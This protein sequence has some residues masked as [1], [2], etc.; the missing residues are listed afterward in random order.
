MAITF[1]EKSELGK[2]IAIVVVLV[3]ISSG[4]GFLGWKLSQDVPVETVTTAPTIIR[5]DKTILEDARLASLEK[6]PV[7]PPAMV[8]A[9][10][11]NPFAEDDG[12]T[13]SS[14]APIAFE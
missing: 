11:E 7:L 3:A 14:T 12:T 5:I 1:E 4:A 9:V 6:F 2:N 10:R 13:A 8:G